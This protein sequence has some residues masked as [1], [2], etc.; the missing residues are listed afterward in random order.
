[1]TIPERDALVKYLD[2]KL[3]EM[4]EHFEHIQILASNQD[5]TGTWTIT[6]GSGNWNARQGMAYR[7]VKEEEAAESARFVAAELN[8]DKAS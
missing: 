3:A 1:M 8:G 6:R 7:F 5:D 4:G 2:D